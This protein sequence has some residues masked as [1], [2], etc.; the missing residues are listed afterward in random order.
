MIKIILVAGAR[1]NVMKITP[2]IC[3]I[4]HANQTNQINQ[5]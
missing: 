3:A 1:P 2:I 4:D 5:P